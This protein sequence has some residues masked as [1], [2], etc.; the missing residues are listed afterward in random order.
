MLTGRVYI[1]FASFRRI[2]YF[3]IMISDMTLFSLAGGAIY[4]ICSFLKDSIEKECNF[5]AK[6]SKRK[7]W[8]YLLLA[9]IQSKSNQ[10]NLLR[11]AASFGFAKAF[12]IDPPASK[13]QK[14]KR[15]NLLVKI[16]QGSW[17][18]CFSDSWVNHTT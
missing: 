14:R 6:R 8:A 17:R 11:T 9:N 7:F 5:F 12:Y 1:L 4:C 10:G 16:S 13:K 18:T 2:L 15:Q 3:D